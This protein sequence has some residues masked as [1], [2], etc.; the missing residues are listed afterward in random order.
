MR[1]F[2][3]N[4][5]SAGHSGPSRLNC[6]ISVNLNLDRLSGV[7]SKK[8]KDSPVSLTQDSPV[9]KRKTT[10]VAGCSR[11]GSEKQISKVNLITKH[12]QSFSSARLTG[13]DGHAVQGAAGVH[14]GRDM[15]G[16]GA[17]QN[18]PAKL[19][20]GLTRGGSGGKPEQL[21]TAAT[22]GPDGSAEESRP[23]LARVTLS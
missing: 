9:T 13:G 10:P 1:R 8:R 5:D 11:T 2:V 16:R 4:T 3:N 6:N 19:Q 17:V 21:R 14:V 15:G 22:I 7:P 18:A 23:I 12:F 20:S